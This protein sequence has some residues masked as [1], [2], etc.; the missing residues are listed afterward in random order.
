M[1]TELPGTGTWRICFAWILGWLISTVLVH[2]QGSGS[3]TG[4][5]FNPVTGEYVRNAEVRLQGSDRLV[6]TES[7]GRF[8]LDNVPAGPATIT[9][10][11]TGYNTA[12]ETLTVA[13]GQT[14]SREI[15]L[16]TAAY[17][18]RGDEAIKMGR[19]GVSSEREGNAKAIMAQRYNMNISTSVASDIFGDVSEEIGRASCRERV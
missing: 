19:F 12:T 13:A 11:Y 14:A 8:L 4:R 18:G 17:V 6:T 15:N 9:V 10:T 3:I 1:K 5:V 2:A 7:D 16:T